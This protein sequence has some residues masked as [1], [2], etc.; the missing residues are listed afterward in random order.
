MGQVDS[1]EVITCADAGEWEAWLA[2]NHDRAEEV[3]VKIAKKGSGEK[4]VSITETLDG[5]LCYGWIDSVRRGLDA[6][7][8]LQRYSPRRARSPWSRINVGKVEAL[9]VAGRMRPAGLAAVAAA[10]ADG[11]WPG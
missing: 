7:H 10:K 4:S 3:W 6:G 11:R 5:A 1:I 8:Y 2:A 9:V